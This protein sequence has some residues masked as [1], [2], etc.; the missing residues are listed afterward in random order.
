MSFNR[1]LFAFSFTVWLAIS[2]Y[3]VSRV[4]A[5]SA[6]FLTVNF[7]LVVVI[8]LLASAVLAA[9]MA[10]YRYPIRWL[11]RLYRSTMRS[12][13]K[14]AIHASLSYAMIP[15]RCLGI[16]TREGIVALR[17]NYGAIAGARRSM[18]F[19]VHDSVNDELWGQVI[20][21]ET[22][23]LTSL[24]VPSNR[25]NG[26]FWEHLEGRMR[27]DPSPPNV[28]LVRELPPHF[29]ESVDEFLDNWR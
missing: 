7:V 24:C 15:V 18:L 5:Q 9:L 21:V 1:K 4:D 13:A 17:I 22:G 3:V 19:N 11:L 14:R 12:L 10:C 26:D 25:I 8:V 29:S 23:E 2:L 6:M 27:F 16:T 20:I 28:Y